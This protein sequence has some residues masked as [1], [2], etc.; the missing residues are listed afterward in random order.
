MTDAGR[1]A[2]ERTM[3]I[4]LEVVEELFAQHIDA[5]DADTLLAV[6]TRVAAAHGWPAMTA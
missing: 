3:P 6:A 1:E 2:V 5:D 4:H